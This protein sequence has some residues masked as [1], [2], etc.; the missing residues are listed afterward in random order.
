MRHSCAHLLATAVQK[1]YPTAKFGVGP[2]VDDG[3]YYDI[4]LPQTI[5][6]VEL[7]QI[8]KTMKKLTNQKLEMKREEMFIDEAIEFFKSKNQDFKVELLKDLK[9]RGTTK[10]GEDLSGEVD[11][12]NP[13]KVSLYHTGEFVDL[14]RGPHV[15]DISWVGAFKLTKVAGAYWRGND[16]NAQMQRIYGF[17][18]ATQEE[19]DAHLKMLEEAKK[20]DHRKLI[21]DLDLVAF[22]ELVGPGLPLWTPR[23]TIVRNALDD[24]VWSLR[25]QYGYEKV[26]I[27]HITKKDLYETSGHW[28]K[29]KDDLFKIVTREGHVFAMKPM[30]CP[31]HT[32]I[33][34]SRQRSYRDLPQRYAETTMVYRDEQSGELAGLTRVRSITQDDAHVFCR[35]AQV[36][37]E[38]F[39]IWNVI[40]AFYEQFGFNLRL[41]LSAHNPENMKAYLGTLDEWEQNVD[42]L[43]TW[44]DER[45]IKDYEYGVGEAA[46]YGPKI[47][48]IAKDAIGREW[49]VAT[50]QVDRNMP[51]RFGLVCVNE[52]SQDEPVVMIHAAIMGA[53]ERFTA[54]FIE[55]TAGAFPMWV[56]PEQVRLVP[57]SDE[58]IGFAK[59][60][61]QKLLDVDVRVFVDS[62]SEG[63]GKKI[64]KAALDKVPW[65][66]VIGQKE[67]EGGDLVVN[68]FGE[69]EDLSITQAQFIDEVLKRAKLPKVKLV[70][71]K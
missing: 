62:A 70:E 60:L 33:F 34:A 11:L 69:E 68:V 14:C 12:D 3:F 20:R 10:V 8:E 59:D 54:I 24:F 52:E 58:F 1:M 28:E 71:V 43:K 2:A 64:R 67:V 17:C 37:A 9:E 39:K 22:S 21:K 23:G 15:D 63:V 6:D 45:G 46:F 30:N 47:D 56:A 40:E 7:K 25:R 41:R 26:T 48:F 42:V 36:R 44:M 35:E 5:N 19:L 27:P 31:H 57:V 29:F 4:S 18:F 66:V 61:E 53:I 65:T 13:D 51:K 49:Q 50:I 32:Q 16:Q 38:A 55:H